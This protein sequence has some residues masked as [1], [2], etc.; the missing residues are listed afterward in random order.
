MKSAYFLCISC[1]L[2]F[3]CKIAQDAILQKVEHITNDIRLEGYYFAESNT[4]S[5]EV[6]F[7]YQDGVFLS[8]GG[9]SNSLN[10]NILS[11]DEIRDSTIRHFAELGYYKPLQYSWGVWRIENNQIIVKKWLSGSGGA[12]PVGKYIGEVVDTATI[13]IAFTYQ[14]PPVGNERIKRFKFRK[15]SPKP[16]STNTFIK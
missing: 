9:V 2:L 15:F 13:D 6:F 10:L 14:L 3:C 1:M 12:Y 4:E 16:D 5:D 8:W 11:P 7:L